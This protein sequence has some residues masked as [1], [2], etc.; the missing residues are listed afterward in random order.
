MNRLNIIYPYR[1]KSGEHT[2]WV[3]DDPERGLEREVL[4]AGID[5]MLD[6]L[7]GDYDQLS[8][9]FSR[10]PFPG[11][12][13]ELQRKGFMYYGGFDYYCPELDI[14]GW[15]CGATRKYFLFHPRRLYIQ[16]ERIHQ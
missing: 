9:L 12:Q 15:L 4:T 10:K 2:V 5:D 14:E 8:I 16:V 6:L 7:A 3:F 13:F 1:I 11:F